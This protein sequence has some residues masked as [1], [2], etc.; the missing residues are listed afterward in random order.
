[1]NILFRSPN[2]LGDIVMSIPA[3]KSLKKEYPDSKIYILSKKG[4]AN[5]F[6]FLKEIDEVIPYEKGFKNLFTI[7]KSLRNKKFDIFISLPNSFESALIGLFAKVPERIG[8]SKDLRCPILTNCIKRTPEILNKHHTFYYL[9]L[10]KESGLVKD[11]IADVKLTDAQK[12]NSIKEKMYDKFFKNSGKIKIG[13][14]PGA[15]YGKTKMWPVENYVE[16]IKLLL[17]E[18]DAT[19][20][21][22]GSKNELNTSIKIKKKVDEVEII[23]GKTTIY[24]LVGVI[25][26]FDLFISNDSGPMH[27]AASLSI[28]QIGIFGSTD[29]VITSPLNEKAKI[30]KGITDCSPCFLKKCPFNDFQCLKKIKPKAVF[31]LTKEF[32]C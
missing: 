8:Y 6:S 11:F 32:F 2:W 7:S 15:A 5:I 24:E 9:N 21:L 19:I 31:K 25:K 14:H 13:I 12:I 10:L 26:N 20:Y 30:I 27:L 28:P 1:M 3:I 17:K 23:T 29:P 4:L 16:L 22:I 18:Y